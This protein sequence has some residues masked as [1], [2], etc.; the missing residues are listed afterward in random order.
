MLHPIP[1]R[2]GPEVALVKQPQA[3]RLVEDSGIF[4]TGLAV[5][6]SHTDVVVTVKSLKHIQQLHMQHLLGSEDIGRHEVHLVTDDLAALLPRVSINT[7][8]A[9]FQPDVVGT[10]QHLRRHRQR[11]TH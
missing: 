9:D 3:V 4:A 7:V 8:A 10:H 11:Q 6:T 2:D 5:V 1:I